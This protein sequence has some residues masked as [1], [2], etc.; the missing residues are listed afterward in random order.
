MLIGKITRLRALEK[1]DMPLLQKWM[2][3][4]NLTKWLGPRFPISLEEQ[5]RW[6]DKL[7]TD[8]T[9]RKLLIED[10]QG[11]AIG[12]VSLM[13][14]NFKDRSAEFGIYLGE[15]PAI[16]KGQG[17]DAS[18]TMMK[19]AFSELG[20]HRLFLYVFEEN[21]RAIASF[22]E[23]G[24]RT[25]AVLRENVFYEGKFHNQLIMGLL[26]EDFKSIISLAE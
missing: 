10:L 16:G 6:Y 4:P 13:D 21:T 23:C 11:R 1:Q 18:I 5:N 25:E 17:K 19:F 22:E 26:S 15:R 14:I 9:K 2:N 12:L 8:P 3:D 24:F 7:V 20:L